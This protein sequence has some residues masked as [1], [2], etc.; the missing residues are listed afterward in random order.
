M[1]IDPSIPLQV[2]PQQPINPFGDIMQIMQLKQA[3]QLLPLKIQE[4]QTAQKESALRLQQMTDAANDRKAQDAAWTAAISVGPDGKLVIDRNKALQNVPGHLAGQ[5]TQTFNQMDK[6]SN[7]LLEQKQKI[8]AANA[9]HGGS[10]GL[11][12]QHTNY[13]PAAAKAQIASEVSQG[14]VAPQNAKQVTDAIDQAMQQDPTGAAA[15]GVVKQFSQKLLDMAGPKFSEAQSAAQTAASRL[16]TAQT[17]QARETR[18]SGQQAYTQ[19]TGALATNPPKDAEA[20][21]QFVDSLP[22]GVASRILQAVPVE[23][24]DP[25]TAADAFNK[26]GM[27]A[28]ERYKADNPNETGKENDFE[29]FYKAW[30]DEKKAPDNA[31]TRLMAKKAWTAAGKE[32][33]VTAGTWQL[34]EDSRGNTIEYNTK[35]GQVRAAPD[36]K[37]AGTFAKD[38]AA[39]E[40]AIGP[41]RDALQ[42]AN[43]YIANKNFTGPGDE[44]LQEKFFE[45]AKPSTGFRMTKQ[46]MDMLQNSRG[47]TQGATALARHAITG[48]WFSDS[49]RKQIVDTMSEIAAAKMKGQGA[50]GG[51]ASAADPLGIR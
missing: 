11:F 22:H 36:V 9:E 27:T 28:N 10:L 46:Q 13:D 25:K 3:Q 26:A 19:A 15:S 17:G 18:E 48:T 34:Q 20:Y 47:W 30:R 5:L 4:A 37:K 51:A 24:Y 50:K 39:T 44:A 1:P 2:R 12:F 8:D 6:S 31:S 40:K 32:E 45:L 43:D 49:Q 29:Q 42:Y 38:A 7:D 23:Q 33:G 16:Q 21:Q 35:T 41:A 14:T